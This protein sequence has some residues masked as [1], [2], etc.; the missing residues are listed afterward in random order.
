M[1]HAGALLIIAI[2]FFIV[3]IILG[4]VLTQ[5]PSGSHIVKKYLTL[6][7]SIVILFDLIIFVEIFRVLAP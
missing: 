6:I 5:I 2:T 7:I 3:A 4:N 1:N